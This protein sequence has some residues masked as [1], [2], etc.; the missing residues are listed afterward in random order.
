MYQ[1]TTTE[2]N[3]AKAS[4][5]ETKSL[6]YLFGQH[7]E[8]KNIE[9]FIVDCFNDVTG[10]DSKVNKLWD[11]QSKGVASLNPKKIGKNLFTLFQNYISDIQFNS[12]IFFMPKLKEMYLKDE[13]KETYGIDNFQDKYIDKIREGLKEEYNRRKKKYPE[14]N[15]IN[16][17]LLAVDFVMAKETKE[18]YVKNITGF[19]PKVKLKE[20]FY[21]TIFEEVRDKQT[22]LKNIDV[23][24]LEI[25]QAKEVLL[26]GKTLWK[27][28]ID[29]LVINRMVGMDL[30][31]DNAIPYEFIDEISSFDSEVRKD[32]IQ[33]CQSD[34]AKLLFNKNS[35]VTFWRFFGKLLSHKDDIKRQKP[36][37]T[38]EQLKI[39][40]VVIP[41]VLGE[42]SV[43][44]LIAALKGG[45]DDGN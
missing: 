8:S 37:K 33:E 12:Y 29:L 31:S 34:I 9:V 41:K 13:N 18:E 20:D 7:K 35:R 16:K 43:I 39:E 4:E 14:D 32:V 23:N 26:L 5:Y 3:N 15:S 36:R 27:K 2:R 38:F 45:F 17:F 30:F 25:M 21:N 11:V 44:Y 24:N 10:A 1:F 40:K 28:E 42:M 19:K 6:F 22:A